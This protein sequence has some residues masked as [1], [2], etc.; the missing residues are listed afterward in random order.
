VPQIYLRANGGSNTIRSSDNAAVPAKL[1]NLSP[2]Q[3]EFVRERFFLTLLEH[4]RKPSLAF[5]VPIPIGAVA[6]VDGPIVRF[7]PVGLV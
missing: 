2:V 1:S 4:N 5:A 6:L 7:A 3:D